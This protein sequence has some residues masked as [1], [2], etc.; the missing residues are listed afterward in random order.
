MAY[1]NVKN[2]ER[3]FMYKKQIIFKEKKIDCKKQYYPKMDVMFN[4]VLFITRHI[5]DFNAPQ[6][7]IMQETVGQVYNNVGLNIGEK[8]NSFSHFSLCSVSAVLSYEESQV[9]T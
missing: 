6:L 4:G 7:S 1:S 5:F 2:V 8:R 9:L 3:E